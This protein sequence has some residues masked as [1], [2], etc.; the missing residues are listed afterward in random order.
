MS[1]L[2][3]RLGPWIVERTMAAATVGLAAA[4]ALLAWWPIDTPGPGSVNFGGR[5]GER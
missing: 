1:A 3:A 4:A 2:R 5:R